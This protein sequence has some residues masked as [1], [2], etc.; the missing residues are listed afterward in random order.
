MNEGNEDDAPDFSEIL[1][2]RG[3]NDSPNKVEHDDLRDLLSNDIS[4]STMM[5]DQSIFP[6]EQTRI[7]GRMAVA[8]KDIERDSETERVDESEFLG[9]LEEI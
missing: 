6:Q 5:I 1:E 9:K 2:I 8:K 3:A 7:E 4:A